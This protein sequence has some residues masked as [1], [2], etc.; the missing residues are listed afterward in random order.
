MDC[1][2][3]S[4]CLIHLISF[5]T[6]QILRGGQFC[7]SMT[8]PDTKSIKNHVVRIFYVTIVIRSAMTLY[9]KHGGQSV[10]VSKCMQ[11]KTI[12]P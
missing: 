1:L 12:K 6:A 4:D 5:D 3:M 9:L 8:S 2:M 10:L 7:G 11:G